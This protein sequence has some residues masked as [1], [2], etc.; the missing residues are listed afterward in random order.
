[1]AK[2][3]KDW[4]PATLLMPPGLLADL[5][6]AAVAQGVSSRSAVIRLACSQFVAGAVRGASAVSVPAQAERLVRQ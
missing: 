1:M 4:K 5:D 6:R 2:E 3:R